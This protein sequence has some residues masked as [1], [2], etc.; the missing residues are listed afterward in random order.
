MSPSRSSP[1]RSG[2]ATYAPDHLRSVRFQNGYLA[3]RMPPAGPVSGF[4]LDPTSLQ[5]ALTE[6]SDLG[7]MIGMCMDFW[8]GEVFLLRDGELLRWDTP[9]DELMPILW[10]SKEFQYPYSGELRCLRDLL[11]PGALLRRSVGRRRTAGR[12]AG[13]LQASTPIVKRS[14]TRRCRA[15]ASPVVC[16]RASRLISG[17]SRSERARRSIRCTSPRQ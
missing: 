4:F 6:F 14:T 15:T 3:L 5:V 13:A 10:K 7:D 8:S 1:A 16:R 11:G 2:C 9:S 17:S 12:R